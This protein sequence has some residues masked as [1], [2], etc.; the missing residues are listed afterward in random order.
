VQRS[1]TSWTPSARAS[2]AEPPTALARWELAEAEAE[3]D[4]IDADLEACG[5][6]DLHA[7]VAAPRRILPRTI[8]ITE[9][10][11][12][13]AECATDLCHVDDAA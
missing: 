12:A 5:A 7:V 10:E 3:A 8:D 1:H 11:L 9:G 2:V 4:L 6:P 13:A